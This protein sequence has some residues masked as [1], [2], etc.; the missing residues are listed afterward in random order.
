MNRS[1]KR[2]FPLAAILLA[3]LCAACSNGTAI[4]GPPPPPP[5]GTF[6]NASVK[7][8]YAFLM[9]GAELCG[10]LSSP[11]TRAGS[12]TADGN[13]HITGGLEDVNVCTGVITLQFTNSTY[14]ITADGRGT[15]SLT[16]TTGTTNYSIALSSAIQGLIAQTD[17]NSTATGSFQRQ[18]TA[19]FSNPAIAGGYVFDFAGINSRK[20][21]ESIIGRFTADGAGGINTGLFDS[22]EAGTASNQLLFPTGAF[23]QLDTNGDGTNFGRGTANIAGHNFAFYIVDATS[24]KLLGADFPAAFSGEAFAQQNISF[25]AASLNTGFAFL[26]GGSSSSGPIATAGRFTADGAG[27]LSA[28]FLDENNNGLV[29]LLPSQGGTVT[30]TYTVD[31]NG[32]GGGAATWTDTKVGTFTFIFYLISPTQAVFQETDSKVTSDGTFHAQTP[33]PIST[34]GL[35]GDFAFVLTGVNS[36]GEEDFIGQLKLTSASGNNAS[37]IMDFNQFSVVSPKQFFDIQFSGPLTITAPGTGPN[38]LTLTTTFPSPTTFN[39]TAYVVDSNTVF[40]VGAESNR[41]SVI[42]GSLSRQP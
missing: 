40:L 16:N 1:I 9:T 26:L 10:G 13:G 5:A 23:Y 4:V 11:F 6:S 36:D 12:F 31:A 20:N 21:P 8:Q 37:G 32:L 15:L 27:N 39:F 18:N 33:G 30:G 22:N 38:T 24:L 14:S 42:A 35:A 3:S 2:F 41:V 29:T 19:A 17:V 34:A 25:T 28:I 7:G